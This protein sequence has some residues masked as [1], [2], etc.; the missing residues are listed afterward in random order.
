MTAAAPADVPRDR[1]DAAAPAA[2]A[3]A[4]R[5]LLA[6]LAVAVSYFGLALLGLAFKSKTT[7]DI[8]AVW[9]ANGVPL[10]ALLLA[11]RRWW[12]PLVASA[13][14]ANVPANLVADRSWGPAL[15]YA[16]VNAAE[17]LV[18]GG[19]MRSVFPRPVTFAT[20]K[21]VVVFAVFA[22]AGGGA[23]GG[24]A[25]ASAVGLFVPSSDFGSAWRLW[26]VVDGLGL[27]AV[28]PVIVTIARHRPYFQSGWRLAE[29]IACLAG[30][31]GWCWAVFEQPG[32]HQAVLLRMPYV[33]MLP[34]LLWAGL[35]FDPRATALLTLTMVA[36]GAWCTVNGRGPLIQ[37]GLSPLQSVV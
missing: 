1:S 10:A 7:A 8:A 17:V 23:L 32:E 30:F 24:L 19:L 20:I 16:T 28:T 4:G 13:F 33:T 11:R 36:I 26:A 5:L 6:C 15:V 18:A 31:A 12:G 9:P 21:E 22:C 34:F 2:P 37:P 25:G 35:R 3:P 14:L 29:K 27:L